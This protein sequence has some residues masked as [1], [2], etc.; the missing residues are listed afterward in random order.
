MARAASGPYEAEPSASSPRVGTP[1]NTPIRCSFSSEFARWRPRMVS[2][3]DMVRWA[4]TTTPLI[5]DAGGA[6]GWRN[7]NV[8]ARDRPVFDALATQLRRERQC[9]RHDRKQP[10]DAGNFQPQF[11]D[12]CGGPIADVA[13]ALR[14]RAGV[15]Q[16]APAR[17]SRVGRLHPEL[18][19]KVLINV[20]LCLQHTLA[21]QK[22]ERLRDVA[23]YCIPCRLLPARRAAP[24]PA[25]R[26]EPPSQSGYESLREI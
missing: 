4:K 7:E 25:I 13:T 6:A 14:C 16:R 15:V 21:A 18:Y 2:K 11:T 19:P 12:T 5:I 23:H 8:P 22:I 26:V 24:L 9:L 3:N 17:T 20:E 10:D 1:E